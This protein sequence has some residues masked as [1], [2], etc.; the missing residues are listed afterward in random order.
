[1]SNVSMSIGGEWELAPTFGGPCWHID[2]VKCPRCSGTEDYV[3][4]YPW[5]KFEDLNIGSPVE[6]SIFDWI[7]SQPTVSSGLKKKE[8]K[9]SKEQPKLDRIRGLIEG[10]L[11]A[12]EGTDREESVTTDSLLNKI[13][14]VIEE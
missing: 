9:M 13:L 12:V 6:P 4:T 7:G 3:I 2:T 1:M 14:K 8:V 11:L 5:D 10:F